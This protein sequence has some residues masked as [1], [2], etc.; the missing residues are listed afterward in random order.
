MGKQHILD[1]LEGDNTPSSNPLKPISQANPYGSKQFLESQKVGSSVAEARSGKKAKDYIAYVPQVDIDNP[2]LDAIR[3]T[4]QTGAEQFGNS[5]AQFGTGVAGG[6]ITSLGTSLDIDQSIGTIKGVQ[7]EFGNAVTEFGKTLMENAKE[8]NP[9]YQTQQGEVNPGDSGWWAQM[10][11]DTGLSAGIMAYSALE[12]IAIGAATAGIGEAAEAALMS[13]RVQTFKNMLGGITESGN[14]ASKMRRNATAFG[15]FNRHNEGMMEAADSFE[16]TYKD[17]LDKKVPEEQAKEAAAKAAQDTYLGNL[18]LMA[19][20]ILQFRAMTFNPISGGANGGI[21]E[22]V[23]GGI[24]NPKLAQGIGHTFGMLS[25][26]GEEYWQALVQDESKHSADVLAGRDDKSSFGER[27]SEFNRKGDTWNATISGI[28]GGAILGGISH[29]IGKA[30]ESRNTKELNKNYDDFIKSS[31][32]IGV[33]MA[34]DIRA[35]EETGDEAHANNLRRKMG[36]TKALQAVHLD[37]MKDDSKAFDSYT[38]YLN[39]VLGAVQS[40]D[41]EFLKENGLEG[42]ED[43]IANNFPNFIADAREIQSIYDTVKV[44]NAR[45]AVPNIVFRQYAL[46]NLNNEKISVDQKIGDLQAQMPDLTNI[47]NP[48]KEINDLQ[49]FQSL[50]N[51]K[52]KFLNSQLKSEKLS[53]VQKDGLTAQIEDLNARLTEAEEQLAIQKEIASN[54]SPRQQILD[55]EVLKSVNLNAQLKKLTAQKIDIE[56]EITKTRKEM[57]T[58]SDPVFQKKN[59]QERLYQVIE[60]VDNLTDLNNFETSTIQQGLATDDINRRIQA[61]RKELNA[62]DEATRLKNTP[63]VTATPQ[64]GTAPINNILG[65]TTE[66]E[67]EEQP[68]AG[69]GL[70]GNVLPA[71]EEPANAPVVKPTV[72]PIRSQL[73]ATI[74][75]N[76]VADLFGSPA[77]APTEGEVEKEKPLDNSDISSKATVVEDE[78]FSWFD[79]SVLNDNL[80]D[81]QKE[82]V[83]QKISDYYTSMAAELGRKP[84]FKE[85]VEDLML[86]TSPEQVEKQFNAIRLGWELNNYANTNFNQVYNELFGTRKSK[87]KDFFDYIEESKITEQELKEEQQVLT[88]KIEQEQAAPLQI[89]E[90]E[91]GQKVYKHLQP[92]KTVESTLKFAHL[93]VPYERFF[94][95]NEQGEI[96]IDYRYTSDSLNQ[97]QYVDSKELMNPNLYQPGTKLDVKVPTES[98]D[99]LVAQWSE[100]YEKRDSVSFSK[101]AVGK[102]KN[103]DEYIGKVPMI[104]YNSE[105]K[106]VAFVHDVDWYNPTNVGY[107]EKPGQQKQLIEQSRKEL[108]EFRRGV[109]ENGSSSITVTEKRPGTM[110]TIPMN[111][112]TITVAQANPQALLGYTNSNGN[113]VTNEGIINFEDLVN[114]QDLSIGHRYD[115]RQVGLVDG[116]KQYVASKVMYEYIDG[117]AKSSIV[118]AIKT[119]MAQ[120]DTKEEFAK[121]SEIK[122]IRD[123]IISQ[124]GLD[125]FDQADLQTYLGNFIQVFNSNAKTNKGIADDINSR[126]G[127]PDGT[128]FL[129]IS[130]G[131]IVMGLKNG[132][133]N[134]KDESNGFALYLHPQNLTKSNSALLANIAATNLARIFRGQSVG[135]GQFVDDYLGKMKQ[136]M[137]SKQLESNPN[138]A[139]IGLDN[140]VTPVGDYST[141]LKGKLKT[142]VK[143]FDLGDGNYATFVQPVIHYSYSGQSTSL[144]DNIE[145]EPSPR[146]VAK[147]IAKSITKNVDTTASTIA[148]I[149]ADM[150]NFENLGLTPEAMQALRELGGAKFDPDYAKLTDDIVQSIKVKLTKVEDLNIVDRN[151]V[152]QFIANEVM[153][154]I[155]PIKRTTLNKKDLEADIRKTFG[156]II[157]PKVAVVDRQLANLNKLYETGNYPALKEVI[158]QF[159]NL[160]GNAEVLKKNWN[161]LINEAFE[162]YISKFT[163]ISIT[164]SRDQKTVDIEVKDEEEV[165]EVNEQEDGQDTDE[166]IQ[167]DAADQ[168]E[169]DYTRESVEDNGKQS[170]SYLL[171][172]F[173]S[174]IPNYDTNGGTKKGYMGLTTYPGF[175]YY[176]TLIGSILSSPN[177]VDSNFDAMMDRLEQHAETKRWVKDVVDKMKASD[178]QMKNTF[179]YNFNRETLS[180]KFVMT[181]FNKKT[182]SYKLKVYDTNANE[183]LRVIQS[184]WRENFKQSPLVMVN[185]DNYG[186]NKVTAQEMLDQFNNWVTSKQL[187]A[188]VEAQKWLEKFG[189]SVATDTVS[190]LIKNGVYVNEG[191]KPVK[192]PYSKMFTKSADT[193]GVFGALAR[194]LELMVA[195]TDTD[196]VEND[197]ISPF[198]NTTGSLGKLANIESK[199]S[200]NVTTN[201]FRDGTKS[202]YGYTPSKFATSFLNQLKTDSQILENKKQIAFDQNSY[203]IDLLQSDEDFAAKFNI[204][205]L[206]INAFKELGKKLYADNEIQGLADADHE[207]TKL[208]MFQDKQQGEVKSKS[209]IVD[210]IKHELPF[211]MARMFFPTMSDKKAMLSISTAVLELKA[212]HLELVDGRTIISPEIK[213]FLSSQLIEPELKRI[214]AHH[215][216]AKELGLHPNQVNNQKGYNLGA[217]IFTM[218]PAMNNLM[219]TKSNGEQERLIEY[220]ANNAQAITPEVYSNILGAIR[221][222]SN[223]LLDNMFNQLVEDKL[224]VWESNG[225]FTKNQ[226]NQITGVKFLDNA[227]LNS[228]QG[229]LEEKLRIGAFDYV[230][231]SALTNANMH[232]LVVGDVANYSQDKAFKNGFEKDLDKNI[233]PYK[234]TNNNRYS[235]IM[236]DIIGVNLGKRLALL[237]AP[238]ATIAQSK[239]DRYVQLFIKD[240]VSVSSNIEYLVELY[241]GKEALR[242]A[243]ADIDLAKAGDE[244]ARIRLMSKFS[245]LD[246]YFD[247]ESTDAQ[248]YTTTKE[249]LDIQFRQGRISVEEYNDFTK[250]INNQKEFERKGQM[251]NAEDYLSDAE[252]KMIFQPIKPVYTGQINDVT[253]GNSRM[254]YIKSSSFPLIPQ[255][256]KAFP[257][258]DGL[259]RKMEEIETLYGRNVRASYDTANKVGAVLDKNQ[260]DI[261]DAQGNFR[262]DSIN[263]QDIVDKLNSGDD[264][265]ALVL[266]RQFFRIQQDVPFKSTKHDHIDNVTVGTQMMKLMFGDGVSNI[267]E[268]IFTFNG[269]PISG[270]ALHSHYNKSFEGWI[271]NEKSKLYESLG[272]DESTGKPVDKVKTVQKLQNMLQLEAKKR[273]FPKQDIEALELDI[274]SDAT[275]PQFTIPL[276]L[277]PNSNR[278]EALLNAIVTNRLLNLKLPG[279]SFVA[280]SEE[281]FKFS[282]DINSVDQSK[283]IFTNGWVGELKGTRNE[284]GTFKTAQVLMPSKFR[285]SNGKLLDLFKQENGEYVY[286]TQKDNGTYMLNQN[287]IDSELLSNPSFR[288][289]TSSHVSLSQIEIVGILPTEVGDLMIVPK[290]FTKQKGLDFDVD[291]EN[292]YMLHHIVDSNGKLIRLEDNEDGITVDNID[293]A[294]TELQE[295]IELQRPIIEQNADIKKQIREYENEIAVLEEMDFPSKD[296]K[297]FIKQLKE[298]VNYNVTA[299]DFKDMVKLLKDYKDLKTQ[300]YQN[301]II[302]AYSSVLSSS[303][304][305]IQRK[306]NKVLSTDFAE[307]QANLISGLTNLE[308]DNSNF[309]ILSDEYQKQKMGLGAAGK[310][311]IGVYSN[312][313]VLHSLI[314]Q[315]TGI[316]LMEKVEVETPDGPKSIWQPYTLNLGGIISNGKLGREETLDGD[317]RLTDVLAERQNT[318]TDNEKLQIMGK[319][320]INELTINV[321]TIL[322]LLGYDKSKE[323]VNINGINTKMSIPY[324]LLSQPV[325]K[326]WVALTRN[327]KS[328]LAGYNPNAGVE[329]MQKL[330]TKYGFDKVEVNDEQNIALRENLTAQKLVDDI[331]EGGTDAESQYAVLNLFLE[332]QAYG[333]DITGLQSKLNI[334]RSG[335]GKSTY[336]M[337]SK[338]DN[339]KSLAY[340]PRISNIANLV[341]EYLIND[342]YNPDDRQQLVEEGYTIFDDDKFS[343]P[344]AVKP[345]TVTGSLVVQAAKSGYELWNDY[346]PHNNG[347]LKQVMTEIMETMSS[348][349]L[350]ESKKLKTQHEVFAEL[351]KYLYSSGQLGIFKG[352]PQ[353][354]R[355][356]LFFDKEGNQSLASYLSSFLRSDHVNKDFLTN[357]KLISGFTFGLEQG[358]LPSLVKY[359]NAR[360]EDFNEEY[361][362]LALVELMDKNLPI[363]DY[364]GQPYTTRMLAKDLITYSFI[365]GGVQEAIEFVKYIPVA[366]LKQMGFADVTQAWQKSAIGQ[367]RV[368]IWHQMLGVKS[369]DSPIPTPSRFVA[370]YFQNNPA[371]LPKL[372]TEDMDSNRLTYGKEKTLED[373]QSFKIKDPKD[374]KPMVAIYNTKVPKGFSKLQIY[375]WDGKQYNRTAN[376]GVFGM[377]EYSV[378]DNNVEPLIDAKYVVPTDVAPAIQNNPIPLGQSDVFDLA[379]GSLTNSLGMMVD[380][381]DHYYP[382]ISEVA[383]ALT[384]YINNNTKLEIGIVNGGKSRGVFLGNTITI[385]K[386]YLSN[387]KVSNEMVARTLLHETIHSL[388]SPVLNEYF[389]SDGSMIKPLSPN[390]ERL[391]RLFSEVQTKLGPQLEEFKQWYATNPGTVRTEADR[392]LYA[393]MDIHEFTTMIMSEPALQQLL[394]DTPSS[395]AG[396]S[397]LQQFVD[398]LKRVLSELGL[399]F[400]EDSITAQ[401]MDAVFSIIQDEV[402]KPAVTTNPFSNFGIM[403]SSEDENLGK[404][405]DDEDAKDNSKDETGFLDPNTIDNSEVT[406]EDCIF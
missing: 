52:L 180:M 80:S 390:V 259:R 293:E 377:A 16:T 93:S 98:N 172:R 228:K 169:K 295:L 40:N 145:T 9:I 194:K 249:H 126:E 113:L 105:G 281:G 331:L 104:I 344:F 120:L 275:N 255:L 291:K 361:K 375:T 280:G 202:I 62:Q 358:K 54:L 168:R 91:T 27:F 73:G 149:Q 378:R 207:A 63:P 76:D 329:V 347:S 277:S 349:E 5:L 188:E 31:T 42:S 117:E 157:S 65:A 159:N 385:D 100:D 60:D 15:V 131:R 236:S 136:N 200:L 3:A 21:V 314:Q 396:K 404:L 328:N 360:G 55:N 203:L 394:A 348:E 150:E 264:T 44:N 184:Q 2:N 285:D 122:A 402:Q 22:S 138:V 4:N 123:S 337:L 357:N 240:R 59:A 345:N 144:G 193:A 267:T 110:I 153:N 166:A 43:F 226:V 218:I 374:I 14:L 353:A 141:Y 51:S 66:V 400:K 204:D 312:A 143:S 97:G 135:N 339:V 20:D 326:D 7:Q 350:S 77:S 215:K 231:N 201:S 298:G 25:E 216:R 178:E 272:I 69:T 107:G 258:L 129:S 83:R 95:E 235:T 133:L 36:V 265:S 292:M 401:A 29:G 88:E 187:P 309:T 333:E 32:G 338:Y 290:N 233:L 261:W 219:Y 388:V 368:D 362:Y 245:Q 137:T 38:G 70:F 340:N 225:Y 39:D 380:N 241:N 160:R 175:D 300:L 49:V 67:E 179:M 263:P 111:Q 171:K 310:L 86:H 181:S 152:V 24:K 134:P 118:M 18:P 81:E 367:F 289:P 164:M 75:S 224:A 128:P 108:L 278:Y 64:A 392:I 11:A 161:F 56:S 271:N 61:K 387:P 211:R 318:A 92:F 252:L 251:I 30:T 383:K 58:W 17:L 296:A 96:E 327:T 142:N 365:Q 260:L 170:A 319:A 376:L 173:L 195:A 279:A 185:G 8:D 316:S 114:A 294:V 308:V 53:Q 220:V 403:E 90:T 72:N 6:F 359:N 332:L 229:T 325:I 192:F 177:Q 315:S 163:G 363:A 199:Y 165:A 234:P 323:A 47:S 79:P 382:G 208:G 351:K 50:A 41:T 130:E 398:T 284:D 45:E 244:K 269:Q 213:S 198:E 158:D 342:D 239:N 182:E 209:V 370:Q 389:N 247:I 121:A 23:L 223:L 46:N 299:K 99:M 1:L 311:G 191:T 82:N 68:A 222:D 303:D 109:L 306:I 373:L 313:V 78:G 274:D 119:Y 246:A 174:Q 237:I 405:L 102:D 254:M 74:V 287:M 355:F 381:A 48:G 33:E 266:D 151:T 155:D 147:E 139:T 297:R 335:L 391:S 94:N 214:L 35:A 183:V 330:G 84:S 37:N 217:Q 112:P 321:D 189:I 366:Y 343:S 307:E 205:H 232:M 406:E 371:K 268:K 57:N 250:R 162:D 210:G 253:N 12:T 212:K 262:E 186:I 372:T 369:E 190:D 356:R 230:I 324:L 238:G 13:K 243:Q 305:R 19:L 301:E 176:Y 354:E 336:E 346:F 270:R 364:N 304:D 341:G 379:K 282:E 221:E 34:D 386:G 116:R 87:A 317:R 302:K 132:K 71:D 103:S 352:N 334:Q 101:W 227:Y 257:A 288:I 273:G 196:F 283:V 156:D 256:T 154:K 146:E 393:G 197:S 10:F 148:A 125:L 276:W 28:F 106:G 320:H 206:G 115:A 322:S 399:N 384:P 167:I 140:K 89:E 397:L 85:L 248:E 26:G 124:T 286:V 242:D 395:T 127:V